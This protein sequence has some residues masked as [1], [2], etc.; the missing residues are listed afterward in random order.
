MIRGRLIHTRS[1]WV[2]NYKYRAG[3]IIPNGNNALFA[4]ADDIINT[5]GI[6]GSDSKGL[7]VIRDC[8]IGDCNAN[9]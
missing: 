3:A 8:I 9:Q 5:A 6:S 4:G 7:A 2:I 1:V